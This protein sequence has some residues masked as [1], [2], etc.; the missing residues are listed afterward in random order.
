MKAVLAVAL[1]AFIATPCFAQ[2]LTD[3]EKEKA[4]TLLK[5]H[6]EDLAK[7]AVTKNHKVLERIM[8]KD[9]IISD[10]NGKLF[11]RDEEVKLLKSAKFKAREMKIQNL[12][13]KFFDK[14]AVV[15]GISHVKA[16]VD[17][18]DI[19]GKYSF[20]Q[21]FMDRGKGWEMIACAG[22]KLPE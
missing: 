15:T 13:V 21:V 7:I 22:T 12:K 10:P 1:V 8:A 5:K 6:S 9:A 17:G 11:T 2:T 14:T 19:S 16:S 20:T 4:I 18:K 3:E